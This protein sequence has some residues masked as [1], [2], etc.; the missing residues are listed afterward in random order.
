MKLISISIVAFG[1]S[2]QGLAIP[3]SLG[4]NLPAVND[5]TGAVTNIATT[6]KGKVSSL[7]SPAVRSEVDNIAQNAESQVMTTLSAVQTLKNDVE[8]ELSS[9]SMI[10]RS[11]ICTIGLTGL[12]V[13][14][15][16]A[17]NTLTVVPSVLSNL[18]SITGSF[19]AVQGA[20]SLAGPAIPLTEDEVTALASTLQILQTLVPTIQSSLASTVSALPAGMF[21]SLYDLHID[22]ELF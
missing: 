13:S 14:A 6:V 1:L 19:Q 2:S 15:V 17:D 8:I 4:Q 12:L 11:C 3:I 16:G 10:L 22:L 18:K 20:T 21:W 7:I 9:M 5:L